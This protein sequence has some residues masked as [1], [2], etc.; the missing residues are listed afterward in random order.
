[1]DIAIL[2]VLAAYALQGLQRGFVLGTLDL[3][4]FVLA[5]LLALRLY[6]A[7][8]ELLQPYLPLPPA[9]LKPLAFLGLWLL[10]DVALTLLVRVLGAPVAPL[11]RVSSA[12]GLLGLVPGALKGGVVVALV[13]ALA[14]AVPLPEP[15]KANITGAALGGRLAGELTALEHTLQDVFGDAVLDGISFATI[16]PQADERV[17]L[18][19]RVAD[20]RVDETA[21][22]R[23]LKLLNDERDRAGLPLL[24]TDAAL[25]EAARAHSRDMLAQGYFA[26]ANNEGKSPAD[27]ARATGAQFRLAGENLALA[28]TVEL[29]HDGLM[30]SPGHRANIL[31][32]HYSRVGI[33]VLDAGL[34]GKMFTQDFA[35]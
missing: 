30:K 8:A 12:N 22:A 13:L 15:V 19:F 6:P 3:L 24:K 10:A 31:S 35:D 4:G 11:G 16:R 14:L 17:D 9:L 34:H 7:G 23:M 1:V 33:G 2:F 29:A 27:R 26:H 21:E 20:G 28:P 32:A 5:L 18:K 25:V